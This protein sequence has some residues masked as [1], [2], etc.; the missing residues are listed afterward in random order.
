MLR[1]TASDGQRAVTHYESVGTAFIGGHSVS[2]LRL[3]LETGRTHQ[4]RVHCHAVGHPIL[5]DI[6]YYTDE[7]RTVSAALGIFS[8]ALHARSLSFTEP[9]SGI[10]LE[11]KAPI[12]EVFHRII[13]NKL[14]DII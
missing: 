3:H 5:G 13:G 9:V 8:Q 11:I 14:P 6:L 1:V 2:L 7:S 10:D 12:P 4:I